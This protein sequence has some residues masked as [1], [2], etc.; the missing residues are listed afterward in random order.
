MMSQADVV[1]VVLLS[2]ASVYA[3]LGGADFGAGFWDL[4][5]GGSRAGAEPRALINRALGPVWEVNHVWLIFCLVVLWTAFGPAF[6]SVMTTLSIPLSLAALGIVLR[7]SGFAFRHEA[8]RVPRQR[9]FGAVFAIASVVTPFS[10][11]TVVGGIVSGRVPVGN[12]AG[13]LVTSWLNPTSVFVGLLAVVVAAYLA[14]V[15]LVADAHRLSDADL[16]DYF[17]GRAVATA[18][19]AGLT[20][21]AGVLVLRADAPFAFRGLA[22]RGWVLML[23]SGLCGLAALFLVRSDAHHASRL[24]AAAAVSAIVWGWGVAQYPYLLPPSLTI[25]NGAGAPETL[26]WLLVVAVAA[27][28]LVV[29]G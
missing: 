24:L 28:L 12:A 14:A 10:F 16:E 11:G 25:A 5:A 26:R 6:A 20:A 22:E 4:V 23:G 9:L 17:R 15:F 18:V 1:A 27:V 7:G 3:V 2:A 8:E 19:C 21:V 13:D 29:P